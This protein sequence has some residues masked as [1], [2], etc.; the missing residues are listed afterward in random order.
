MSSTQATLTITLEDCDSDGTVNNL[1]PDDD[2]DGVLDGDDLYPCD[3]TQ[4]ADTDG[5]G[6]GDGD[7][8]DDDNDGILDTYEDSAGSSD[9]IDGDGIVNSKD[10][11]S[12]GD[13]CFDVAEA[14]LSDPDGDGMLGTDLIS[15]SSAYN[16]INGSYA[17]EYAGRGRTGDLAP[18]NIGQ[19]VDISADGNIVIYGARDYG[20]SPGGSNSGHAAVYKRTPTGYLHG[21]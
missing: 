9:D 13:G 15:D 19:G 16:F 14:G 21:A 10:L 11:D 5:D 3:P 1:D 8:I 17:N 20:G 6:I 7:D 18:Y 2:N 4:S 12:D